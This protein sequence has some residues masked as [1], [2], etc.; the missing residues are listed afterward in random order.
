MGGQKGG[1]DG[2]VVSSAVEERKRRNWGERKNEVGRG[3][4]GRRERR[5]K[6]RKG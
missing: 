3:E 5:W 2:W 1:V 4:E 6:D